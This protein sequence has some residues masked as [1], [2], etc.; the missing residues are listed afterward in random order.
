MLSLCFHRR[1][2]W[3]FLC[4]PRKTMSMYIIVHKHVFI[5]KNVTDNINF[6]DR[7]NFLL[8]LHW[9]KKIVRKIHKKLTC[10]NYAWEYLAKTYALVGSLT[11]Y[12]YFL[13][14]L[15]YL[16]SPQFVLT[17]FYFIL[18]HTFFFSNSAVQSF[19]LNLGL[20][21]TQKMY[22]KEPIGENTGLV[23]VIL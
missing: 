9:S 16:P 2:N 20:A 1:I 4:T 18:C 15:N 8:F 14:H 17:L 5:L 21:H 7:V 12:K 19:H 11:K 13:G 6:V 22:V 3:K 10:R 23:Y